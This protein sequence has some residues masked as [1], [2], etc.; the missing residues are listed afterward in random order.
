M[1]GALGGRY[2]EPIAPHHPGLPWLVAHAANVINRYYK[3]PDGCSAYR[4][5][6]GKEYDRKLAEFG[7]T[8]MYMKPGST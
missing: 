2:K 8:I 6:K 5:L 3:G 7:E 1:K 4:R